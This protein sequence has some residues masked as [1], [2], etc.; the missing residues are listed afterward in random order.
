MDLGH[1]VY[2]RLIL[3]ALASFLAIVLWSRT[4]DIA[5]ML[6]IIGTITAYLG[7]LYDIMSQFGVVRI[8]SL[9]IGSLSLTSILLPSLP[10]I[11]IIAAFLVMIRR[12]YRY[13]KER[14]RGENS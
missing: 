3:G 13:H 4:R 14:G 5:W 9:T 11:F 2:V 12:K 7:T 1:A 10:T 6:V 8:S